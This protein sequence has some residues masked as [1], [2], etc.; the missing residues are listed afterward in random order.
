MS[1]TVHHKN[2]L[3]QFNPHNR[4]KIFLTDLITSPSN[5]HI[6]EQHPDTDKGIMGNIEFM[7]DDCIYL[8]NGWLCRVM[9]QQ[10][11]SIF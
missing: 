10:N 8:L 1:N 4:L 3:K 9:F 5:F 2:A 7:N 6:A 11:Y